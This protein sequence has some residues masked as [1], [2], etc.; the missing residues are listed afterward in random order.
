MIVS[1]GYGRDA[2]GRLLMNF[3]PLN[4]QGGERRLN[5]AIT[6]ARE[7][8]ILVSSLLPEDIDVKRTT[9]P[10]PRLLREY[11]EYARAG[12]ENQEPRTKNQET[13][14]GSRFSVLG[15]TEDQ[16]AAA[17]AQRGLSIARQI[18]HSDF[19]IDIAIRNTHD[20]GRFVLGIECDGDDYRDAPTA[21]DRERLRELV[22]GRLGWNIMR[23][24]SA[25]WAQNADAEIERVL[26]ATKILHAE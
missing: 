13:D 16:L 19:R 9:H 8:V 25:D 14:S 12:G 23:I 24:W 6:R 22:L 7:Q 15:S 18:G 17:L 20:S 10:G 3:G 5:V 26:A 21:R 11:L 2:G 4:Q 1:V